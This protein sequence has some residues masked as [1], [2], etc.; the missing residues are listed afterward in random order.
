MWVAVIGGFYLVLRDALQ[1]RSLGKLLFGLLVIS[2][3]TG[4]PATW[5]D[6]IRRNF[7]F[8]VPPPLVAGGSLELFAVATD[9]QGQRLGDRYAATQVVDGYGL[10]DLVAELQLE[11]RKLTAAVTPARS[12][13]RVPAIGRVPEH[14]PQ[15]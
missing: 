13:R 10:A 7:L 6:S 3:R 5:R 8:L 12:R 1:G 2:L 15:Q 14:C 11:G 9:P 4:Q